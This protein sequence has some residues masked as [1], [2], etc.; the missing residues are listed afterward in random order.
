LIC[1]TYIEFNVANET[2]LLT[3]VSRLGFHRAR[4]WGRAFGSSVGFAQRAPAR[5][6]VAV[7]EKEPARPVPPNTGRSFIHEGSYYTHLHP[8]SDKREMRGSCS[9]AR[10]ERAGVSSRTGPQ[11]DR[12]KQMQQQLI[13]ASRVVDPKTRR[14]VRALSSPVL[15][16][17]GVKAAGVHSGCLSRRS[18][19]EAHSACK[20]P[21][22]WLR[23]RKTQLRRL[24]QAA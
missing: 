20:E 13:F 5:P 6:N 22:T 19:D 2:F 21:T 7:S 23:A 9:E 10:T 4:A 12:S 11:Q 16:G 18:K 15:L 1:N 14:L 8:R 24:R 3:G 17:F